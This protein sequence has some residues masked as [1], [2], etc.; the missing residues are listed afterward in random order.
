VK[1]QGLN[2]SQLGWFAW[3]E[4]QVNLFVVSTS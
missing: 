2:G 4:L 3:A 1:K